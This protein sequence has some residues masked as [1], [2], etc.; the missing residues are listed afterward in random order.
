VHVVGDSAVGGAEGHVLA[1]TTTLRERG[2]PVTFVSPKQGR[3]DVL[4]RHTLGRQVQA[5]VNPHHR[6]ISTFPPSSPA[7]AGTQ[8]LPWEAQ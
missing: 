3:Y 8:P 5:T 2:H 6:L 7:A 4:S 1:L